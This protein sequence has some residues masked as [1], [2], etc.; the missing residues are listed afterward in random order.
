MLLS[1]ASTIP[2][3]LLPRRGRRCIEY[4]Y[5]FLSTAAGDA[6]SPRARSRRRQS[7]T[8]TRDADGDADSQ[9][10]ANDAN[11][12]ADWREW[13]RSADYDDPWS[14]YHPATTSGIKCGGGNSMSLHSAQSAADDR[15]VIRSMLGGT[16]E[17]RRHGMNLEPLRLIHR[18]NTEVSGDSPKEMEESVVKARRKMTWVDAQ[19]RFLCRMLDDLYRTGIRRE[20]END[21]PRVE[22]CHRVSELM[23]CSIDLLCA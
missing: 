7:R 3:L 5:S 16:W 8:V 18:D 6:V 12:R 21:R 1:I 20:N 17:R 19:S 23:P 2:R 4:N 9:P 22:R 14:S 11:A 15:G 10:T 13:F